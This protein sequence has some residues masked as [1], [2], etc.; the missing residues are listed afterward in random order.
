MKNAFFK[1][2]TALLLSALLCAGLFALPASAAGED[3]GW[4]IAETGYAAGTLTVE[5]FSVSGSEMTLT[6]DGTDVPGGTVSH[7]GG[8]YRRS[9]VIDTTAY[10]DGNKTL[11]FSVGGA[12]AAEKTVL[13]DN[14]APYIRSWEAIDALG[15]RYTAYDMEVYPDD[16]IV[17]SDGQ[18]FDI[19]FNPTDDG[20]GVASVTAVLDGRGITPPYEVE[21]DFITGGYH[22]M[23]YTLTDNAGNSATTSLR[24]EVRKPAPAYSDMK[25]SQVDGGYRVSAKLTGSFT[26]YSAKFCLA[27]ILKASASEN[28]T[29]GSIAEAVPAGERTMGAQVDGG[30][31]TETETG[32]ELYQTFSIDVSGKTGK[33]C[34]D[35][36]GETAIG[37]R[38]EMSVY[39][40]I[41]G[42]WEPFAAKTSF[43]GEV[44][45]NLGKNG[46][47]I[48]D[49]ASG[50][51]MKLRF[52][53][54]SDS[55]V[56]Y[57][58]T[59]SFVPSVRF[60]SQIGETQTGLKNSTAAVVYTGNVT[61]ALG[62][63]IV[64]TADLYNSYSPT[65][66][67]DVSV[68]NSALLEQFNANFGG[69]SATRVSVTW[70]TAEDMKT[71]VQ[72]LPY[73]SA[74]PDFNSNETK[75]YTGSTTYSDETGKYVH[76]LR[77]TGL[78][79]GAK[80]WLRYGDKNRD[81]WSRPCVVETASADESFA[82]AAVAPGGSAG[83]VR[84]AWNAAYWSA[85]P[86]FLLTT[87]GEAAGEAAWK[88]YFSV[89]SG[90]FDNVRAVPTAGPS[91]SNVWWT[92]YNISEQSGA[93]HATG[94]YYSFVY[95]NALFAVLNS[96][97]LAADGTLNTKQLGWLT[98]T[99]G[100]SGSDW[101]FLLLNAP[102][103]GDASASPL[104]AQISAVAAQ[105]GVDAVFSSGG[106]AVSCE[107]GAE[108]V[109]LG[110][111]DYFTGAGTAYVNLASA[112][113][114]MATA[115]VDG[116]KLRLNY[117]EA[118]LDLFSTAS[119]ERVDAR[120]AALPAAENITLADAAAISAVRGACDALD[121][122][123]RERFV[124][125][126]AELEAA[127]AALAALIAAIP[128]ELTVNGS[129]PKKALI[130]SVITLPA[131][132]AQDNPDGELAVTVEVIDPDG[133][134][135]F[136]GGTA[137]LDKYGVYAVTYSAVDSDGNVTSVSNMITVREYTRCDMNND[138]NVTAADALKALRIAAGLVTADTLDIATG[139]MDGDGEITVAD[140][141][142]I[143]RKAVGL[144]A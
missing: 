44:S 80:Y 92:K 100:A 96:N 5:T 132:T 106:A 20:C 61:S 18:T 108:T 127:E 77:I 46:L 135:V 114:G 99:L 119:F 36:T 23:S 49:Y 129:L 15:R 123:L 83:E 29:S 85:A 93:G 28:V 69:D 82:F 73:G 64:G 128:P 71:H 38:I 63:Y 54:I 17:L 31:L 45:F 67:F 25:V 12:V 120:I 136:S 24:F 86:D 60:N 52:R 98:K 27:E 143:L 122:D 22:N 142:R 94:V 53:V 70:Q 66:S 88:D 124:T 84:S 113:S 76:K 87:G 134:D 39:N 130:G 103:T 56:K 89:M 74:Y 117:G 16:I 97:D 34:A 107:T 81:V 133:I 11:V 91:D 35:Y 105:Y 141:L 3:N 55:N 111:V 102:I 32:G 72:L 14:T 4:N 8:R 125:R 104:A 58:K 115:S 47:N 59:T 116:C 140:A 33:V 121:P 131:A 41:A 101:N 118:S 109:T 37:N 9:F 2:T 50:G 144:D 51:E 40:G 79:A 68:D 126:L 138:G 75:N 19:T 112:A 65:R 57:L 10:A 78:K 139:D 95:K 90:V 62:W 21:Y 43:T 1:K 13:F 137:A 6:L 48:A 26:R 7:T 30:L 42:E 110:G